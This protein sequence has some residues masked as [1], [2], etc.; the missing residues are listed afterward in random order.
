M[1]TFLFGKDTY[2]SKQRVGEIIRNLQKGKLKSKHFDLVNF[3]KENLDFQKFKNEIESFSMFNDDKIII[4]EDVFADKNFKEKFL[5]AADRILK[6]DT[7]VI[8][9][10]EKDIDKRDALYKFLQKKTESEE[11][12]PLGDEELLPWVK[13]EIFNLGSEIESEAAKELV[14][15]VGGDLWQ[16]KNEAEKLSSFCKKRKITKADVD[17]LVK[18]K[19]ENDIFK[20]IDAIAS[21]KKS[22][23][24][25]FVHS[26]LESGDSPLY[27]LSMINFQFRNL[28]GIKEMMEKKMS[29]YDIS[30]KSK[31]HPFV[32]RKTYGQAQKFT[33]LQ[34]KKIYRK[35]FQV[36]LSI[37]TGK[38][39]P[40]VAL[41]LFISGI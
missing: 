9:R 26:H 13:K 11:F 28:I 24:L 1:I 36:D 3:N 39:D 35:I 7:L 38:L 2:R 21:G 14:L 27:L 25:L 17:M 8:I 6:S 10:E 40:D 33:F 5:E 22:Q 37:K 15:F 12:F 20:T 16:M 19:I 29:Y 4:L 30:K 41:D 18:P 31:L 23:A 34:L 32:V